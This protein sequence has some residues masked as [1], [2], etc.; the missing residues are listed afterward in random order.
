MT[1][2]TVVQKNLIRGISTLLSAADTARGR[3]I[4]PVTSVT[5]TV[6]QGLVGLSTVSGDGQLAIWFRPEGPE[7]LVNG[8]ETYTRFQLLDLTADRARTVQLQYQPGIVP[9]A[10]DAT[11][12]GSTT[13]L[14]LVRAIQQTAPAAQAAPSD[15]GLHAVEIDAGDGGISLTAGDHYRMS[16]AI[17]GGAWTAPRLTVPAREMLRLGRFVKKLP[18]NQPVTLWSVGNTITVRADEPGNGVACMEYSMPNLG[19]KYVDFRHLF[20]PP[21][22]SPA[23]TISVST[24]KLANAM[25]SVSAG[26]GA[27]EYVSL[28]GAFDLLDQGTRAGS[29]RLSRNHGMQATNMQVPGSMSGTPRTVS[30]NAGYLRHAISSTDAGWAPTTTI[31]IWDSLYPYGGRVLRLTAGTGR[32]IIMARI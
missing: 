10:P 15:H 1:H 27:G 23:M 30:V 8:T 32:H 28:S 26:P 19:G 6:R 22:K 13:A 31:D 29:I 20:D 24:E 21:G 3:G 25:T 14:A 2:V 7:G 4:P 18:Y 12:A 17:A 11:A 16:T 9:A 5:V